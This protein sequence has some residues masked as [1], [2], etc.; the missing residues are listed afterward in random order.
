VIRKFTRNRKIY[1]N[2]DSALKL[3]YMAI[4]EAS[5]R[6][7]MPIRRWKEALN[8]FA[9]MFEGRMPELACK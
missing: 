8:H 6:W 7:T 2:E 1:P 9:I 4:R 3:I 5:G